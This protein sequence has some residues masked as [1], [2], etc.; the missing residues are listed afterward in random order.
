MGRRGLG[1]IC[2]QTEEEASAAGVGLEAQ[3]A[4]SKTGDQRGEAI[5]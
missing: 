2:R 5:K 3:L 4:R 1:V